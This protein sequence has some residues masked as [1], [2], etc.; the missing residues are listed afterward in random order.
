MQIQR[1]RG[2]RETARH[3]EIGGERGREKETDNNRE[4]GGE[5]DGERQTER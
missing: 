3:T 2:E 4:G 5:R 1:D